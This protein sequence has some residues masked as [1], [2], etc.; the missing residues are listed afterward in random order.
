V[1]CH[2]DD[3]ASPTRVV[4]H[5]WD[6]NDDGSY[7]SGGSDQSFEYATPGNYTVHLRVTDSH[8]RQSTSTVDLR[9]ENRAPLAAI[10]LPAKVVAGQPATIDGSHSNDPDGTIA[11][12][13]WDL[14]GD[15]S[16]ERSG[17]SVTATFNDWGTR[18]IA[19]RVTDDWGVT[20][21]ATTQ[22]RVLAPPL[23]AG[24]VTTTSPTV[25]ASTYFLPT[26]SSDPDGTITKYQWDFNDDGATDKTTYSAG[27]STYWKWTVAGSYLVK[28]TVTDNDGVKANVLIPVT[29]R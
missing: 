3:S 23:A 22:L 14:D 28:L 1:Y 7:A 21:V 29:V 2:A 19:L 10:T 17:Q 26:G 13:Q 27:T 11:A 24:V 18:T 9:V 4:K 16:F 12:W 8:G 5:E 15:G 25:N 6:M 20:S